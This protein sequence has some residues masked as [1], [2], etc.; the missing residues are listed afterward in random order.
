MISLFPKYSSA[1]MALAATF[2][3]R[4]INSN[5]KHDITSQDSEEITSM[6]AV[7]EISMF[8]FCDTSS[9]GASSSLL[10]KGPTGKKLP[11]PMPSDNHTS[12][13]LPG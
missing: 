1:Y 13:D 9:S 6:S 10:K 4:S 11:L 8:N 7:G 3:P 5:C 2:P 12:T